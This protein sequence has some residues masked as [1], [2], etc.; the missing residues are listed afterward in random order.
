M[1]MKRPTN[2]EFN[3]NGFWRELHEIIRFIELQDISIGNLRRTRSNVNTY[4]FERKEEELFF[5]HNSKRQHCLEWKQFQLVHSSLEHKSQGKKS[6]NK[7]NPDAD[8]TK[9]LESWK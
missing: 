3:C 7:E 6:D 9:S 2:L 8:Y 5:N 4:N 1:M